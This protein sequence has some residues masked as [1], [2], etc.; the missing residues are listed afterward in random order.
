MQHM[1]NISVQLID[2]M[3][4]DKRVA[5]VARVSFAND[6]FDISEELKP[7]D[8]SLIN[9]LARGCRTEEYDEL[10]TTIQ[11]GVIDRNLAVKL[12]EDIRY[13]ATHWTPFAHTAFTLKIK[14]PVPI[15]TQAFKH[16]IGLVPNEES[17]RYISGSPE[18]FMPDYLRAKPQGSIKQGSGDIHPE[19]EEWMLEYTKYCNAMIKLYEDMIESGICPEQAR[20]V[21]PQG[22]MV[23]WVWTGNLVAFANF[24]NK[25][26]DPHAQKEIQELAIGIKDAIQPLMPASWDALTRSFV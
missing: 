18:L 20:F 23:N 5:E 6:H 12:Y 8:Q 7:K 9:F 13:Q 26:I 14:A 2:H 1:S 21:L 22:V 10:L 15:R 16:A 4:T 17:R 24:Y 3:G 11:D 19:N 25:R